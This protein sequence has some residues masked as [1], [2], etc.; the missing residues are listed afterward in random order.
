MLNYNNKL[1]KQTM[2]LTDKLPE[3]ETLRKIIIELR[4]LKRNEKM[5]NDLF[6]PETYNEPTN[7]T[8][9]NDNK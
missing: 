4:K 8:K 7:T 6:N 1:K 9:N 2:K 5:L 3:D